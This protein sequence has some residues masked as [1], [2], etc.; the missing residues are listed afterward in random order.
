MEISDKDIYY[1]NEY[2]R[3]VGEFPEAVYQDDNYLYFIVKNPELG[4]KRLKILSES[5]NKKIII[6]KYS[7][8]LEE[9]VKLFFNN[10]KINKYDVMNVNMEKTLILFIEPKDVKFAFGNNNSKLR[11]ARKIFKELFNL[12]NVVLKKDITMQGG[13]NGS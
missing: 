12:D 7:D 13:D 9:F 11:A 3:L 6:L 5:F 2:N 4:L 1:I 8:K 10:S